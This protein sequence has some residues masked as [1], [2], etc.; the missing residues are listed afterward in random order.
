MTDHRLMRGEGWVRCCICG[1]LHTEPY[2]TLAKDVDGHRWD[3][4][5]GDCAREAGIEEDHRG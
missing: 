4:C 3:V 2:L 1:E 5:E